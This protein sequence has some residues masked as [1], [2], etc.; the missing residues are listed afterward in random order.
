[1]GKDFFDL[2]F[3]HQRGESV[4]A[5]HEDIA[6]LHVAANHINLKLLT[7]ADNPENKVFQGVIVDLFLTYYTQ[8]CLFL[9]KRMVGG[10]LHQFRVA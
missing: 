7:A 9:D 4:G 3:R 5:E 2:V 1:M 10:Q 6:R 8:V